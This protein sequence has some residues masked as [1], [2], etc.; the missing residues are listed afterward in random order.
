MR[1]EIEE[2]DA[3]IH[4]HIYE[5]TSYGKFDDNILYYMIQSTGFMCWFD[6]DHIILEIYDDTETWQ[7]DH[8]V[9]ALRR[10]GV[11]M[12]V[13]EQIRGLSRHKNEIKLL[14]QESY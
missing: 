7:A 5:L 12:D 3:C 1:Y 9:Q 2:L 14:E 8:M 10:Y 6:V 4:L 11:G 13:I